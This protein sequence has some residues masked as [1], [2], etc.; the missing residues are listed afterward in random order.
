V[1]SEVPVPP[2]GVSSRA[3]QPRI[4]PATAPEIGTALQDSAP[5]HPPAGQQSDG[6]ARQRFRARDAARSLDGGRH[7]FRRAESWE[8]ADD[9]RRRWPDTRVNDGRGS[10]RLLEAKAGGARDF[11]RA[12]ERRTPVCLGDLNQ[13]SGGREGHS[14]CVSLHRYLDGASQPQPRRRTLM[15]PSVSGP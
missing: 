5:D 1:N 3:R 10:P 15:V 11:L 14:G 8:R 6:P 2:L 12:L 7:A 4:D 13:R 9:R